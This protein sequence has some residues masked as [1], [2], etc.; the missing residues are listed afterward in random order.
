MV[1]LGV[2]AVQEIQMLFVS[3]SRDDQVTPG[4][5]NT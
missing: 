5:C 3:P 4:V 1:A 2:I